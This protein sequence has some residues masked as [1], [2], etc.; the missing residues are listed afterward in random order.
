M[1]NNVTP[2]YVFERRILMKLCIVK[3]I[4]GL[5]KSNIKDISEI[6]EALDIVCEKG[7]IEEQLIEK[8]EFIFKNEVDTGNKASKTRGYCVVEIDW[9]K[10]QLHITNGEG[11]I[12]IDDPF[13]KNGNHLTKNA[14]DLALQTINET[15]YELRETIKGACHFLGWTDCEVYIHWRKSLDK[16]TKEKVKNGFPHLGDLSSQQAEEYRELLLSVQATPDNLNEMNFLFQLK[17]TSKR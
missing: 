9:D 13:S 1:S 15:L 2:G 4:Q 12:Y 14:T 17:S 8:F 10:H 5:S 11:H 7:I 3:L 6:I 16:Q